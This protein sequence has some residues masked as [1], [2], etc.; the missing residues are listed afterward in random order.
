MT[1][2]ERELEVIALIA[3]EPDEPVGT[4]CLERELDTLARVQS[5]VVLWKQAQ[6]EHHPILAVESEVPSSGAVA[7]V[8]CRINHANV[9]TNDASKKVSLK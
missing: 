9:A 2:P 5:P 7:P 1:H 6:V 4:V 3:R 8:I